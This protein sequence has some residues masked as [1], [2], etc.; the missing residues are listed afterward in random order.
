MT[1]YLANLSLLLSSPSYRAH[2]AAMHLVAA[3]VV[4][5]NPIPLPAVCDAEMEA[6]NA[7]A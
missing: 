1:L 6:L 3:E 5:S 7:M 2:R 4:K